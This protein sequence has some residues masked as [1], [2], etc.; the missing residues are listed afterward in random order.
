MIALLEQAVALGVL[1]PLD[2]VRPRGGERRRARYFA[3]R[4]LPERRGGAGHVCLMLEQLQ[5][6]TLFEGRQPAL[7]LAVWEAAGRPDSARW[8]QRLAASAAVGDGSSATPLVLRGPRLYLQRMWQNEGE[9]AAFIGGEGESLAVPEAELRIILDRLFGA[10]SD[11][12]DWQ[13][14]AAAVAPRGVSRSFPAGLAPVKPPPSP[15]CWRR[16]C[17]WMKARACA[18]SWRHRPARRRRA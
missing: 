3:G 9:V 7:A 4:R 18:F 17:S 8:Q 5:A 13:K 12:P 15:S 10:A 2:A 6:D 1:R 16:W 14:I 11:E